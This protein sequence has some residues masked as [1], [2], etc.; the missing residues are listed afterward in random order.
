MTDKEKN[1][2]Y[3]LVNDEEQYSLWSADIDIP[4]GWKKEFYGN[5]DECLQYINEVW[6]DMRPKSIRD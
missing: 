2:F 5:K 6:K 1:I 3:V 4:K